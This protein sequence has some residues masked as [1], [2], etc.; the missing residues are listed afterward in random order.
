MVGWRSGHQAGGNYR[1]PTEK[2]P[3]QQR[4]GALGKWRLVWGKN[5]QRWMKTRCGL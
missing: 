5:Q 2:G 4:A 1:D 3:G